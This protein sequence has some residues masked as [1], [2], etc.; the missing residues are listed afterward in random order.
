MDNFDVL[1]DVSERT[2]GDIYLGVVGPVR[3]GKSTFIK[4]FMEIMV[5]PNIADFH[6]RERALDELPQSGAGRTVMT[7]E[8][9]FVPAEAVNIPVS[10]GLSCNVRLVDCVGYAVEGALGFEEED[11]PRMVSTP[12]HDL[13]MPFIEAAELGTRKVITDHSTIG[14]VILSDGSIGDIE[15]QNFLSAEQRVIDELQ[16]L[17]KPYVIILNSLN[18]ESEQTQ[19]LA[20]QL[21]ADYGVTVIPANAAK[22]SY[23]DLLIILNA[24]LYEFPVSEVNINL[25]RW[26]EELP[27]NHWL[28]RRLEAAVN[29]TVGDVKKVRDLEKLLDALNIEDITEEVALTDMA[30]GS[31]IAA[32]GLKVAEDL[33]Y[34][35][36]SELVGENIDGE[37][38]IMQLMHKFSQGW[39]EWD[40]MAEAMNEVNDNGYGVVSP[41]MEEIYLEEPELIKQGGHFGVR[42]KASAPS[43][44][45][46]RANITTEITPLI[47]SEKQCEDLVRYI[48]NEFEDDP[49]KIWNT[50][51]FGKSLSDLVSEGISGKLYKMPENVQ[52]KLQETLQ[53]IV[54]DSGGGIVCIII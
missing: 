32:I 36:L 7:S 20:E 29:D 53:K 44:H 45:I 24:A 31:G 6:E 52:E 27:S 21:A 40:K 48:L 1:K 5:L 17:G 16:A 37:H 3:T 41:R 8:P 42:L 35:I 34:R 18:P 19:A 38:H 25:P 39:K 28:R 51:V 10:E 54:N 22:L 12:W 46:I 47:G 50:N 43:Y 30:L 13:P 4:R 49:Q 2:G 9:K 15:R 33:F 23:D 14:L 11:G 26:I